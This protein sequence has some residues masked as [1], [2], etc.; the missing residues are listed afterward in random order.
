MPVQAL[1]SVQDN[2][3][4]ILNHV[5]PKRIA[6]E[7]K[8]GDRGFHFRHFKG[9]R[10]D[11]I[12]RGRIDK[13]AKREVFGGGDGNEL[14]A[15]LII[16]HWNEAKRTLYREMVTHVQTIDEDVEKVEKIEAEKAN[17]MIDDLLERH[18]LEDIYLC[19]R[20]NGV[21]FSEDLIQ[22]RLVRGEPTYVPA[23][24]DDTSADD[25]AADDTAADDTAADDT[26]ADDTAADDTAADDTAADDTAADD[27]AADNTAADNTATPDAAEGDSDDSPEAAADPADGNAGTEEDASAG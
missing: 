20:L 10:P 22:A 16:V 13:I 14:F 24:A 5:H 17:A 23:A 27:T 19:V 25:T 2:F 18:D 6:A 1:R 11:K 3:Q 9:Y 8:V 21:R 4:S 12:G 26:A 7:M 15:N